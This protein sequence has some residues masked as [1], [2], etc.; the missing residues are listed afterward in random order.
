MHAFAKA[1]KLQPGLIDI[2]VLTE[3][4][5]D[6]LVGISMWEDEDS[7]N[8]AMKRVESQPANSTPVETLRPNPPVVRQFFEI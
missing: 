3:K 7:I 5:T 6:T 2:H 4:G 8:R 1:F